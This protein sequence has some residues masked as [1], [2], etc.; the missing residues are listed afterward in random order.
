[1]SLDRPLQDAIVRLLKRRP[2]YG[3][4]LLQFR[5][6]QQSGNR[7]VGVT[8]ADAIPT[9]IVDP[10]RFALFAPL[11]QEALLEHLLKHILHLHPCRRRERNARHWDLTCDLAINPSIENL[12]PEAVLP[13][14]FRLP[15]GLAAEEYYQRL[16]QLPQLGNQQNDGMGDQDQQQNPEQESAEQAQ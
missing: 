9:L 8:I 1:M 3:Q 15:E 6:R 5:R 7:A 2:F 16:I 14:Q 12:P 10:R 4:F 11:E 13:H